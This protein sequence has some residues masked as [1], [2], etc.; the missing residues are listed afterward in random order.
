ME[1]EIDHRPSDSLL[2]VSLDAGER[3]RAESGAMV[4]HTAGI[5]METNATGGFLSSIRRSVVGGESFFQNT[6]TA[7]EAG[8][9][10]FAPPLAGDVEHHPVDGTV[11]VQSGSYIAAS[12]DID[13]DTEFGGARTFFGSEGLFLLRCTG[14]GPL[15]VSSY[16]AIRPVDVRSAD[17]FVV[18]TGHIVAFEEGVDFTVRRVGGLKSTL[19]SGEGLVAEFTGEGRVWLQTRSSDALLSWLIPKLPQRPASQ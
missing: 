4:S 16:G 8:E 9:V 19:A 15:F 13:V 5:E 18:D 7:R 10:S 14:V 2:T 3:I 12:P 1:Y 17:P 6:F 11:Y